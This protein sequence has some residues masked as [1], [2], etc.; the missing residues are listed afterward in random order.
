[1]SLPDTSPPA[2]HRE[3]EIIDRQKVR[4][5]AGFVL[6]AMRRHPWIATATAA[7][8]LGLT[9]LGLVS[10]PRVYHVDTELLAQRNL[11]MPALGNPNRAVPNEADSPTLAAAE[12]VRRRDNLVSLI[13]ETGLLARWD[14]TRAPALRVWD[15]V[16]RKFTGPPTED[17]RLDDLVE[18]LE[19]QLSVSTSEKTITISIDWPDKHLAHQLVETALQN[20]LEARHAAEV[21][22]IAE[23]ISILERHA[24][25]EQTS[26][27][28]ALDD[29]K[30]LNLEHPL[31]ASDLVPLALPRTPKRDP[32][33][34]EASELKAMLDG[35][36]RAIRELEE[37]GTRRIAEL[38]AE[39]GQQKQVYAEA[40]P[41]VIR[42]RQ[43]VAAVS[44][45][46]PQ[47]AQLRREEAELAAEYAQLAGDEAG[48][49]SEVRPAPQR[50]SE[51]RRF[52]DASSEAPAAEFA[53]A[54]LRFAMNKYDSLMERLDAARIELDTTRAAFKY[55]Y[56]TIRPAELPKH[57]DKPKIP[58]VLA[59]GSL[60]A[61]LA[62]AAASV[63]VD[64]RS[65]KVVEEWQ[66]ERQLGL[67][68]L[69]VLPES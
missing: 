62:A 25:E 29:I 38:Q 28:S 32:K 56:I 69:G 30:R 66:L 20:F 63:L 50:L 2:S 15:S 55:R 52:L 65:R 61:L 22:T 27:D 54:R 47:L 59:L 4:D 41:T 14:Q 33:T 13:K 3:L 35:K 18:L 37:Y 40:H 19:K 58:L 11:M 26:V 31:R 24:A 9:V 53:K 10:F 60:G 51:A 57:A 43:S 39:L 1:V 17:E 48:R 44:E 7:L 36:R 68:V 34:R 67:P 46:S 21:G 49:D 16:V 23:A 6:G 8:V 45:E 12:T 64:I 5:Y 42:L